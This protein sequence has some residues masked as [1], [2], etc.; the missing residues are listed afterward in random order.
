M[1]FW[2]NATYVV[3]QREVKILMYNQNAAAEKLLHQKLINMDKHAADDGHDLTWGV[4]ASREHI[5]VKNID[6]QSE[7]LPEKLYAH[8]HLG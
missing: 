7:L 5:N 2:G 3:D 6:K 4:Y 8:K 1:S